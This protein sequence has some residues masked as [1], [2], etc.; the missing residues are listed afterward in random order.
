[1]ATSTVP[2]L[3]AALSSL[4]TGAA[5][6]LRNVLFLIRAHSEQL[7]AATP[8]QDPRR[9]DLD[10]IK[11]AADRG[12]QLAAQLVRA[13][14]DSAAP[15]PVD[16]NQVVRGIEPLIRRLVGERI[17]VT[18]S[19]SSTPWLVTA[20]AVQ[21]EQIVMNL[22]INARD[23]MP[24]GGRLRIE[25][26]SRTM[27]GAG[28]GPS[29]QCVAISVTDSGH[30]VDPAVQDRIFEPYFT[31][32]GAQGTGV[33]LA[34]V[35]AIALLNG[36]HVEMTTSP[37]EGTTVRVVLPRAAAAAVPRAAAPEA[38]GHGERI[39][40]VENE[41]AIRDYLLRCLMAEGYQ[42]QAAASGAEAL[43]F[44]DA[45]RAAV[46]VVV[47]DVHLPDI[48]GP[49]VASRIRAVWPNVGLVFMSGDGEGLGA[50]GSREGVPVLAKPFTTA[51]LV[52]AVRSAL[53]ADRDA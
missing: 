4:A 46:D 48:D 34:T 26:E 1:M 45:P 14:R 27:S 28:P 7:L 25:T 39:L 31:T 40:L 18:T 32:K 38:R 51:Q 23:A 21:I 50:I 10:A 5:H 17:T 22:S 24:D 3:D 16:V 2:A 11:D 30:G 29:S 53:P 44:C 20:N 8:A 9:E 47:A 15:Q 36:G 43:S 35:R 52:T 33:G 6:D 13:G 19:L 37:G 12:A 42:V 41:R 49:A